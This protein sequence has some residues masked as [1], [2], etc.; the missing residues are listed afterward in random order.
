[1][2]SR[3]TRRVGSHAL[4]GCIGCPKWDV[5]R[6]RSGADPPGASASTSSHTGTSSRHGT[7][8]LVGGVCPPM[9]VQVVRRRW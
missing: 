4:D 2:I 6:D 3:F 8:A 5:E 7:S 1:M 9:T